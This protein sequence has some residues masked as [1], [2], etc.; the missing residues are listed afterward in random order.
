LALQYCKIR[1]IASFGAGA[2]YFM[3]DSEASFLRGHIIT[4]LLLQW[5]KLKNCTYIKISILSSDQ[6]SV[7]WQALTTIRE[8]Q[9]TRSP[10]TPR[11]SLRSS[12]KGENFY[13]IQIRLFKVVA[14]SLGFLSVVK[15]LDW[16]R[17]YVIKDSS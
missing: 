9:W 4:S 6:T 8:Y 11:T 2:L 7:V 12:R 1:S 10:S 13:L 3:C 15:D 17:E 5:Q 14:G 16:L